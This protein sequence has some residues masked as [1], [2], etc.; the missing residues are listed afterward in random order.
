MMKILIVDD[1]LVSREKLYKYVTD[2]GYTT[3]VAD[4]GQKGFEIWKTERP[5]IVIAD[6]L[7]PEM[8]GIELLAHIRKEEGDLLTY[9]IVITGKNELKEMSS[10]LEHGA[11]D[12]ITKPFQKAELKARINA[13]ERI[14]DFEVRDSVLCAL[15]ELA[16]S[17]DPDTEHHLLRIRCYVKTLAEELRRKKKLP[18]DSP[19][20]YCEKLAIA[21]SLHDIGKIG[22]PDSILLKPSRLDA[23][24]FEIMKQHCW[25]G[26]RTLKSAE[27]KH[28]DSLYLKLCKDIILYHHE[29]YDGT[30]YPAGLKGK[31]ITLSAMIVGMADVYDALVNKRV[32]KEAQSHAQA[33]AVIEEEARNHFDPVLVETFLTC[34]DTMKRIAEQFKSK[35]K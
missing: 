20:Q 13:A 29:K 32:Y 30:G 14:I 24:E 16:E 4:D 28:H 6:W 34:G 22:I 18:A 17:R 31:A 23:G 1:E 26:F 3:F 7:M 8:T 21:S 10:A 11:D 5:H 27:Q 12:F 2:L 19:E 25:I 9:V 33:C 35:E 15:A